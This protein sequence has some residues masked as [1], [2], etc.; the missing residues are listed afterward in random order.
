MTVTT[1]NSA[2]RAFRPLI[3]VFILLNAGIFG[4]RALLAKHNISPDVLL[5][6]NLILFI[7]TAV[8]FY[9]YFKSLFNARAQAMVRM[10]YAGMFVKLAL[11]LFS[12]FL[13]IMVSGKEVNKGGIIGCMAFY[14]LYT[15]L[16]VVILL[17]VSKQKKNV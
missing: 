16:E 17:K 3:V 14:L 13:Y 12:S 15:V 6:G 7:A 4:A 11:C 5:V 8:S 2:V 1:N 10:I 9:F